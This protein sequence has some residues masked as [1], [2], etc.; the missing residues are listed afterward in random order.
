MWTITSKNVQLKRICVLVLLQHTNHKDFFSWRVQK[1]PVQSSLEQLFRKCSPYSLILLNKLLVLLI[2]FI[3]FSFRF[4]NKSI[5]QI[6]DQC[7]DRCW[8]MFKIKWMATEQKRLP[9]MQQ[10]HTTMCSLI[11][12]DLKPGGKINIRMKSYL[13]AHLTDCGSLQGVNKLLLFQEQMLFVLLNG[14]L[15]NGRSALRVNLLRLIRC[16]F[17]FV[18]F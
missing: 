17:W 11:S 18:H 5:T 13:H 9:V 16:V 7:Q 6:A 4:P 8:L 14:K 12:S 3:G 10:T 2:S 1:L 15:N